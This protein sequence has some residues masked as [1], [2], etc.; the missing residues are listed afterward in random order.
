MQATTKV[1]S[2]GVLGNPSRDKI[3][4]YSNMPVGQF[5]NMVKN[6]SRK[7]RGKKYEMYKVYVEKR[8]SASYVAEI[9][10]AAVNGTDA[11][12]NAQV[13]NDEATWPEV[14]DRTDYTTYNYSTY[15]PRKMWDW[16]RGKTDKVE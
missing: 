3:R 7:N 16:N 8:V 12:A 5:K 14:P 15:D 6:L 10:V 1:P 4:E 13:R 9:E 2:W 11:L